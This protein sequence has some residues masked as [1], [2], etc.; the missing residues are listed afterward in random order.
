MSLSVKVEDGAELREDGAE[1]RVHVNHYSSYSTQNYHV[2]M[3]VAVSLK[4][5]G[6]NLKMLSQSISQKA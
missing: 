6:L 1:L 2:T 5:P 4:L 3:M